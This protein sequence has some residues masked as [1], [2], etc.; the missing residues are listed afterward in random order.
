MELDARSTRAII[1]DVTLR[2]YSA[3][4][5]GEML[6]SA[7][8]VVEQ[9]YGVRCI[10]DYWGDNELKS[11]PRVF[12]QLEQL[13]FALTERHPYKLLARYFQVVARK[14]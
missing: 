11:D 6:E 4:E 7:G 5:V 10:C 13:E 3:E 14:A 2:A 1:F 8:C 9:D 12:A